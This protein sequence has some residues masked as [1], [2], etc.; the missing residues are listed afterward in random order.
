MPQDK[1]ITG[2]NYDNVVAL[3]DAAWALLANSKINQIEF[4]TIADMACV[5]RGLAAALTGGVRHLILAKM[6]ELDDRSTLETYEDIQDA[7]EA[8]IREKIIEG[9]LHRFEV[10]APYRDQINQLNQSALSNPALAFRLLDDL[11]TVVRRILVMSGDPA[12][13][14]K[15][16]VRVKGVS[17]VYLATSRVWMKDD[18]KDLVATMKML[19]QRMSQAEEWGISFRVFGGGS[20]YDG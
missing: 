10:Y 4:N 5:D 7:G 14:L 17:G 20:S 6:R 8:S 18:S 16:R 19:D 2:S 13:G 11:G 9:L 15:G 1:T 12:L 3:Y